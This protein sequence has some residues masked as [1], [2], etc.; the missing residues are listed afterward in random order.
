MSQPTV[1]P[2]D[3]SVTSVRPTTRRW[4][5]LAWLCSLA[6]ITYIGRIGTIQVR[7]DIES[8]LHLTP[9]V[10]AWALFSAFNLAYAIFEIPS[11][12]LGDK[13]GP[14]KV[15]TRIVLCW[16]AFTALTGAAWNRGSLAFFR[17][18]FG[19]GEAGAFPNI[20]RA[21]REWFPF[22]ERGLAQG[23]IWM[24]ARWGGAIAPLLMMTL[25]LPFGKPGG[26]RGAFVLMGMLGVIW[27]WA[28][29]KNFRD[30]PHDDADAKTN[31]A[32]RALIAGGTRDTSKPAP[33][34]WSTML[35]SPTLWSLSLMYF[36]SNAGWSFF[37]SWITPYLKK[38]LHLTGLSLV[39]ASGGPLFFGGISCLLGGF[40]TDRQ[41]RLWGRRWGRTLLG[42]VSYGFAG[43]LLL[44]TILATAKHVA[45][46]YVALCL[47]SFIKD[48]GLASSW[49]TTIDVG[50]RY[51]G[52]V[53]GVMNSLGNLG[54]VVSPPIVAWMAVWAGAAGHPSWKATLYYYAAMFFIASLAWLLVNPR[55]V[56]VYS[57]ADQ[58]RLRAEGRLGA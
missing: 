16:M 21:S 10:T 31:E 5:I 18:L 57:E 39:L 37:G 55:K 29:Y 52:T 11:G 46:A 36:C 25:A 19:A 56:I 2:D 49:A 9:D 35:R 17:F 42:V 20:A 58:Q 43:A 51:S 15:L 41:V 54:Q 1:Q 53:A 32:E 3:Q 50:H 40:L 7:E 48:F 6:A 13:L 28:F 30:T 24:S 33:L 34:S 47:S 8:S 44:L 27:V 38:D 4:Q 26:W 14:R 23:L 22:R 12:R 45:L